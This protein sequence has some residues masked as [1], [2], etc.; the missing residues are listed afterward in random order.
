MHAPG[1]AHGRPPR[2][3]TARGVT[4]LPDRWR[5]RSSCT[6]LP[7]RLTA[8]S[9]DAPTRCV[10]RLWPVLPARLP[11]L[12]TSPCRAKLVSLQQTRVK[13]ISVR[14]HIR[15]RG[16]RQLRVH[17]R[18]RHGLGAALPGLQSPLL[19]RA[20]AQG[21]LSEVRRRADRDRGAPPRDQ[22]RLRHARE[23]QA[24]LAKVLAA[25][26]TQSFA[27]PTRITR[28]G[29]P[30]WRVAAD[31]QGQ[32]APDH[33]R[34]LHDA[35]PRAHHPAPGQPA[36]AEAQPR[37][38]STPSTPTSQNTAASTAAGRS[39][40]PRCAACTPCCTAPA[41]TPCAGDASRVNPVAGADPPKQSAEHHDRLPV[42]TA[43]QLAAFLAARRRRSPLRPLAPAGHDRH[44]QGRGPRP[45]AGRTSTW[46]PAL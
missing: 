9:D 13:E 45:C 35:R 31:R 4:G 46:R 14:G 30:A 28:Q 38:P 23:C 22:G 5:A 41:T 20:Q 44:A 24:A 39:R 33:L 2:G 17:R 27:P 12:L 16:E 42:W 8:V 32:P 21:V 25:L 37:P 26:E 34:L 7:R 15:R 43:E 40:P 1:A 6:R 19:G 11:A 3:A 10:G 18:Y 36:A 29:L